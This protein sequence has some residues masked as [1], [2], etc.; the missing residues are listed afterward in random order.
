MSIPDTPTFETDR[1]QELELEG[2]ITLIEFTSVIHNLNCTLKT[3]HGK[4]ALLI[5]FDRPTNLISKVV[6]SIHLVTFLNTKV[7]LS[8]VYSY[9]KSTV[10][11]DES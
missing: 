2:E 1:L 6:A 4:L 7:R 3:L 9:N 11:L 8:S 10:K 5:T